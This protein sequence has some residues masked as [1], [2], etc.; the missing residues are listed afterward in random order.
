MLRD[1]SNLFLGA[2]HT[3]EMCKTCHNPVCDSHPNFL[4][5]THLKVKLADK[6]PPFLRGF[7]HRSSSRASSPRGSKGLRTE[8]PNFY[9]SLVLATVEVDERRVGR[10]TGRRFL[11]AF[12][13]NPPSGDDIG[14]T[15]TPTAANRLINTESSAV[16]SRA[17]MCTLRSYKEW[18]TDMPKFDG[19]TKP[20]NFK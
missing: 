2:V 19:T 15:P 11:Y 13:Q 1:R 6:I 7:S 20:C 5:N 3:E 16:G 18:T 4:L 17:P 10:P 14:L 8:D 9:S 12:L